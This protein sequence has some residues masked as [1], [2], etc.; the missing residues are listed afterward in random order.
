MAFV[1]SVTAPTGSIYP[2]QKLLDGS[3]ILGILNGQINFSNLSLT[4]LFSESSTDGIVA[5]TTQ[6]QAGATVL[7]AELN[8]ISTVATAGNSVRL[9][10]SFSGASIFVENAGANPL[11]MYGSAN[12]TINGVAGATGV[13]QMPNSV[14][15][16]TCYTAGAWFVANLGTGYFGSLE[17]TSVQTGLTAKAGGGQSGATAI[18]AMNAQFSTVT[19]AA[20]SAV[21]PSATGLPVG[22]M[23]TISVINN[24]ANT[25]AVFAPNGSTMNGTLNG[26]A[27]VTNSVPLIFYAISPT[28]WVS[29]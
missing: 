13:S 24:G 14:A 1:A 5:G 3:D 7:A 19:T 25:M 18:T 23:L 12:D 15:I 2:G 17:T 11:Q 20:D 9:P 22:A 10:P 28:A 29:K 21:L 6:S 27:S 16:Y 8:K 26:S 4:G